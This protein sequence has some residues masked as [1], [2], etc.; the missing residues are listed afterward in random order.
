MW[1]DVVVLDGWKQGQ[2][3]RMWMWMWMWAFRCCCCCCWEG[4]GWSGVEWSGVYNIMNWNGIYY[5]VVAIIVIFASFGSGVL[6]PV[7][8]V[9]E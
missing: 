9:S 4:G 1:F 3:D 2:I 8:R 7:G 5:L 6:C